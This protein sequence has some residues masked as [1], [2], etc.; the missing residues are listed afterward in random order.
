M[1]AMPSQ[2][3]AAAGQRLTA[4][5]AGQQLVS[6]L[7][8]TAQFIKILDIVTIL[9]A[10]LVVLLTIWLLGSLVDHWLVALPVYA[11][12]ML[13]GLSAVALV[14]LLLSRLVP[15]I[16]RR[17]NPVYAANR[18]EQLMPEFKNGLITWLEIQ[19]SPDSGVPKGVQAALSYRAVRFLGGQD[20]ASTVDSGPLIKLVGASLLLVVLLAVYAVLSPKS[21]MVSGKRLAMP[22]LRIAAPTRIH[23]LEVTPGNVELTFGAPLV[24]EVD[25]R[26]LS[27]SDPAVVKVDSLDGQIV[28]RRWP[29]TAMV[30]GLR[31]TASLG[32]GEHGV[33]HEIDYWIEAGDAVSGPYRVV[34]NPLPALAVKGIQIQYP[35][36]TQL[37]P[38]DFPPGA[39]IDALEGSKMQIWGTSNQRL[40][41]AKLVMNPELD[42]AGN[43]VR[44]SEYI[45]LRTADQEWEGSAKLYLTQKSFCLRGSNS[46]GDYNNHPVVQPLN[47]SR[48]VPPEVVLVGPQSRVVRAGPNSRLTLEVR[49]S[50]VDFGLHEI[51]LELSP[52]QQ[53]L[54]SKVL[55]EVSDPEET[56]VLSH[57]ASVPL[58]L[59]AM[60]LKPGDRVEVVAIAMDTRHDP[61]TNRLSPN[62]VKSTP[63]ILEIVPPA[64]EEIPPEMKKAAAPEP[65]TDQQPSQDTKGPNSP[66]KNENQQS[67]DGTQSPSEDSPTPQQEDFQASQQSGQ[68]KQPEEG[69]SD[70]KSGQGGASASGQE[71]SQ[72]QPNSDGSP[73]GSGK[74]GSADS[75]RP[76][77]EE[78]SQGDRPSSSSTGNPQDRSGK[79]GASSSQDG[80]SDLENSPRQQESDQAALDKVRQFMNRQNSKSGGQQSPANQTPESQPSDQSE[81]SDPDA[82]LPNQ[83]QPNNQSPSNN[84]SQQ[85]QENKSRSGSQQNQPSQ[86]T[87]GNAAGDP[88]PNSQSNAEIGEDRRSAAGNR[89][90]NQG[91]E[92]NRSERGLPADSDQGDSDQG[93]SDQGDSDQGDSDQ[94]DSD[95]GDSDQGDSSSREGTS[96]SSKQAG[97]QSGKESGQET[98]KE[99]GKRSGSDP[100]KE[101]RQESSN[102]SSTQSSNEAS[103]E[104]GDDGSKDGGGETGDPGDQKSSPE[105]GNENNSQEAAN[106]KDLAEVKQEEGKEQGGESGQDSN[107]N[108]NDAASESNGSPSSGQGSQQGSQ[109]QGSQEQG[110]SQ[111][112]QQ[113]ASKSGSQG[114]SQSGESG[115]AG[116]DGTQSGTPA[117]SQASGSPGSGQSASGNIASGPGRDSESGTGSPSDPR[118]ADQST[119]LTLDYLRRQREQP[120]AELLRE[121]NW[122]QKDLRDFLDRYQSSRNLTAQAAPLDKDDQELSQLNI[123]PNDG[124]G[125]GPSGRK[126]DFRKQLDSGGRV[127]PPERLRKQIE[128]FQ[129]ALQQG[130]P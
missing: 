29:L 70:S 69:S 10:C 125:I 47:V 81:Q 122:T 12:W 71:S 72:D 128:E 18:I 46:R 73:S 84:Q 129:K 95:Q 9:A 109:E 90:A 105:V 50:D 78:N 111:A 39:R 37:P 51:R 5:A 28:N 61:I 83:P 110:S 88:E 63:L 45:D 79:Q 59:A 101:S 103:T 98:G 62:Q 106:T 35:A 16:I 115:K 31:Y 19:S 55:F 7:R 80:N 77:S 43:V 15:L 57:V 3:V 123:G 127:R 108:K 117:G 56:P 82:S 13:W 99:G 92:Q 8:K 34:L 2:D 30:E 17:I 23:I 41:R 58:N 76:E 107:E 113:G 94:G 26:G 4:E 49:A 120:D 65:S 38:Q 27:S 25:L 33:E 116:Q 75:S 48:D 85:G 68:S 74:A 14:W 6:H 11:R 52:S 118:F 126:D 91:Q 87:E 124:S 54:L 42:E 86:G 102:D 93:D 89:E 1:S 21:L 32:T 20:P 60:K 53:P 119:D 36:Y 121:L 104:S 40:D 97:S 22:W 64:K 130:R 66:S 44:A 96:E 100:T 114:A 67:G 24:V 112:G